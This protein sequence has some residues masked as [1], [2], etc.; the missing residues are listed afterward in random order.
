VARQGERRGR[1][2][3][4]SASDSRRQHRLH[5]SSNNESAGSQCAHLCRVAAQLEDGSS[6]Q[7]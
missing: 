4:D 3:V 2:V 5:R 1:A 7:C 6:R